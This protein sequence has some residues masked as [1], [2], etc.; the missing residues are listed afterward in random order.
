MAK[1]GSFINFLS[2]IVECVINPNGNKADP[3]DI[4]MN[5]YYTSLY[6]TEELLKKQNIDVPVESIVQDK[7]RKKIIVK[8]SVEISTDE[9]EKLKNVFN[10]RNIDYDISN[11]KLNSFTVERDSCGVKDERSWKK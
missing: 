10:E 4:N 3:Y 2:E 9:T 1:K 5:N 6:D 8:T 11:G 7:R